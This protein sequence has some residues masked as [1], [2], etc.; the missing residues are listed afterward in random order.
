MWS[1]VSLLCRPLSLLLAVAGISAIVPASAGAWPAARNGGVK[2]DTLRG[3][4]KA[5]YLRGH[6]GPDHV[7]GGRGGDL[8]T[9]DTGGD[10][11]NGGPGPDT[12]TG[13]AGGDH[14]GGDGGDDVILGGFGADLIAGGPGNDT[15]D[16]ANDSDA[17]GGGDGDDLLY[18]G[19]GPDVLSGGAGNDR[20]YA[21]S[22]RDAVTGGDGD[23]I[24]VIE[25]TSHSSVF[26]GAGEDTV[27]VVQP[28]D[29]PD[30]VGAAEHSYPACE[31]VLLTDAVPDP[32][33]GTKYLAGDVGGT[34]NGTAKDDLLL[35]GPGAD[36]LRGLAGND[37]LWGLRQAGLTSALPDVIDGGP[38]DDTIYGGPGPQRIDAGPGDDFVNGGLG[39]GTIKAGPGDDTVRL[40]GSG[41]ASVDGGPG[42]DTIYA[43]GPAAGRVRCGPGKDTA[44]AG[45][46]D[47][48]A[49]DCE[50]VVSTAGSKPRRLRAATATYADLVRATPGL[51]HWWRLGEQ[52]VGDPR[53]PDERIWDEVSGGPGWTTGTLGEPGVVDDGDTA[54]RGR[55][56][57]H[58]GVDDRPL[59]G[60][61]STVELWVRTGERPA[62]REDLLF[63]GVRSIYDE[64]LAAVRVAL[65]DGHVEA[66]I[67]PTRTAEV[68]LKA[69]DAL[70]TDS[71]HHIA[72]TRDGVTTRLYVDG[73]QVAQA[74]DPDTAGGNPSPYWAFGS[75]NY[76]P[77]GALD[78]L[79]LY[80]RALS[81]E[82]VLAH[83]RAGDDA[84]LPV[85]GLD[86]PFP[87]VL[88]SRY[89]TQLLGGR[90]GTRFRCLI[91]ATLDFACPPQ[92]VLRG[93]T[94]GPHTLQLRAID[95]FG[96]REAAPVTY[97]FS[98]DTT[99]PATV[100]AVVRALTGSSPTLVTM[101]SDDPGATFECY[102][103]HA[104]DQPAVPGLDQNIPYRPCAPGLAL[105]D[106]AALVS[107]RAVGAVGN[108]DPLAAQVSVPGR[109]EAAGIIPAFGGARAELLIGG[110]TLLSSGGTAPFAC[111]LDQRAVAACA[112][113]FRLPLLRHGDHVVQAS[114]TV[115][116]VAAPVRVRPLTFTIRP[117]AGPARL[118]VAQFPVVVEAGSQLARR[119]PRVRLALDAPAR[120][121]LAITR[122]DGR[123]VATFRHDGVAGPNA[124]KI[125]ARAL[126]KLRL[127]RYALVVTAQ[128]ATGAA[129]VE[130]LAFAVI[131]RN[132]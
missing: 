4:P 104:G 71:W 12:I 125:P 94:S 127:G 64:P 108:R 65:T 130:R 30:D 96:R 53:L 32:N 84:A 76:P 47:A 25:S 68:S 78:E 110:E 52:P 97:S 24:V 28:A 50:R 26:C 10:T 9:G 117:A 116:G 17:L 13:A 128:A 51:V 45:R 44:Y 92:L 18:G 131:P 81:A 14:L 132:R 118:A 79:A 114:Q 63:D 89:E 38:G 105:D 33:E 55:G 126:Q 98:V 19:S 124:L 93:L 112:G 95:R 59:R 121:T 21:G 113:R 61:A 85:A 99:T 103:Q 87:R 70:P 40:R 102:V 123:A 31:H 90:P 5:D 49:K 39:D 8:L 88:P 107:V 120:L 27:Y 101:G 109:A 42:R 115:P 83:A 129:A 23:D 2:A 77:T 122:S 86:R 73:V 43:N 100:A 22:G 56:V 37:V 11:I 54:W 80:D 57:L 35:G 41:T 69:P 16:G 62:A 36:T 72:F 111:R 20:L 119:V 6:E 74:A 3:G 106:R 58:P 48:V 75:S 67:T 1:R 66:V 91:D 7:F 15:L 29:L 82:T 34:K 46:N 60:P